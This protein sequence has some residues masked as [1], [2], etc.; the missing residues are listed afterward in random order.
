M[1]ITTE[2][3]DSSRWIRIKA[4]E[5]SVYRSLSWNP[6]FTGCVQE[7]QEYLSH[8]VLGKRLKVKG[9][10]GRHRV[11]SGFW[12]WTS[13]GQGCLPWEAVLEWLTQALTSARFRVSASFSASYVLLSKLLK[14]RAVVSLTR[15]MGIMIAHMVQ[16]VGYKYSDK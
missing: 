4:D 7:I 10:C 12:R 15:K 1:K 14:P 9:P 3:N 8:T 2:E 13:L 6:S 5:K 16:G 11:G